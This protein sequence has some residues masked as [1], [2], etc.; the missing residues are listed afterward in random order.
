MV[1]YIIEFVSGLAIGYGLWRGIYYVVTGSWS[2]PSVPPE[3][4][5]VFDA[6]IKNEVPDEKEFE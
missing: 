6:I 4:P 1:K 3:D 5:A 2:I